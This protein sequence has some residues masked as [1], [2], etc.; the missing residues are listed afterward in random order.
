[1][2]NGTPVL[3]IKPY[4]PQYDN[5]VFLGQ[6]HE[7]EVEGGLP[8]KA[9]STS[10]V[11]IK[12]GTKKTEF[13]GAPDGE[14]ES[15]CIPPWILNS[16]KKKLKVEFTEKGLFQ[17]NE[18]NLPPSL[19]KTIVNIL[20]EDPRSVYLKEKLGNQFFTFLIKNLHVTCKFD[21]SNSVVNVYQVN[22]ANQNS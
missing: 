1:M 4:I 15:I 2:L 22:E 9:A 20:E 19:Q 6:L 11:I 12:E 16:G 8:N 21:D 14:E 18:L 17:I 13:R 10:N 5:P 7:R 3:D